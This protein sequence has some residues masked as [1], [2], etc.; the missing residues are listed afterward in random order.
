MKKV[1]IV[2]TTAFVPTGGL[3]T[4]MLNY[5][6]NM[7]KTGLKIDF[8]STNKPEN[9]LVDEL[10]SNGSEYF[11]L[12]PRKKLFL[13]FHALVRLCRQYDI[14]HI[15]ANSATASLELLCAY[16]ANVKVRIIH[17][18]TCRTQHPIL[19]KILLPLY[20]RLYTRAIA[21]SNEAGEWLYGKGNFIILNNAI[22]LERY[23][24]NPT[25]RKELRTNLKVDDDCI[26]IGNV[27]KLMKAKNHDFQL[28]V[29]NEYHKAN[30]NS[31][32]TFVGEGELRRQIESKI[33]ELHLEDSVIL[34]GLRNDVPNL[35]QAFDI[36]LF[37]SI[38]E[39]MPLSVVEAQAS[40]L[41]CYVSTNVTDLIDIGEDVVQLSLNK[42]A[43]YWA[44]RMLDFDV[45]KER[46]DRCIKNNELITEAGYNIKEEAKTLRSIYLNS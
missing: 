45:T 7:D 44:K 30:R 39:G 34:T 24:Y 19:N 29:F 43:E 33:K 22:N 12:P 1:L 18:H 38:Y 16:C 21:C 27:G 32:L 40:G 31:K 26:V 8:C 41:P 28:D 9:S 17:N 5:Y 2:I 4:V 3:S 42:G 36:F 6:R 23:T 10:H 20:N 14:I 11:K 46:K 15:N 37:P 25:K 13:Y 35:L